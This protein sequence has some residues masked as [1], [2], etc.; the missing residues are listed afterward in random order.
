MANTSTQQEELKGI[1]SKI[2]N[3]IW[4]IYDDEWKKFL[5]MALMMFF[6]LFNYTMLRDT[7]DSLV[8]TSVGAEVIPFLKGLVVM[9]AS[10][11]F[12]VLYAKLANILT[13]QQLFISVT[14]AFIAFFGLFA[15]YLYPHRELLHPSAETI[16]ALKAAY[17]NIQHII[18]IYAIWTYS[19]FYM[20]SE[21]WGGVMVSLLFWQFANEVTRTKEAKRFYAMFGLIANVSL[22]FS[23]YTVRYFSNIQES[24]PEGVDAWGYSLNYMMSAVVVSGLLVI[25]IYQWMNAKILTNPKFYD[26]VQA[27]EE[28]SKKV[29]KPKLSVIESFRYLL[30]SKYLGCIALLILCYGLSINLIEL[31]WKSQVKLRFPSPNDYNAFMG[32]FSMMTGIATIITI[33]FLKGIV[34]RYGWKRGAMITP[35]VLAITG[36]IFFAFIFFR[37]SL[38]FILSIVGV[39]ALN[40][41]VYFGA[42]QNVLSKATKYALFDPTKEMAYIPLDQEIKIK[43]KAAVDVIGGRLGKA[44]GGYIAGA[45]LVITAT[46]D[47]LTIAPLLAGVI[48]L[49]IGVWFWAVKVLNKM[50]QEKLAET[51]REEQPKNMQEAA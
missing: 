16:A 27:K 14:G 22:I 44:S 26:A 37:D 39:T 2:R 30:T 21:L 10:I 43:G 23:G 45:L 8:V 36:A 49:V 42:L 51:E 12:V 33:L 5:P 20:F 28:K 41:A 47:I 24:L 9:P 11:L 3:A 15:Y 32:L 48:A 25:V 6:I 18:S 17:P 46:K 7:K 29:E 38:D 13:R 40:M 35:M 1:G 19:A 4:P 31:I 50:Y 34:S